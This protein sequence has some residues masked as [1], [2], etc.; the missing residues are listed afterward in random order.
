VEE[1]GAETAPRK[2]KVGNQVPHPRRGKGE[3]E[4]EATEEGATE[5]GKEGKEILQRRREG[6]VPLQRRSEVAYAFRSIFGTQCTNA[7]FVSATL[8]VA[9]HAAASLRMN[10]RW[11]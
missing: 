9:G 7:S 1:E 3:G 5:E 2:R 4:A 6:K 8:V 10:W 11:I